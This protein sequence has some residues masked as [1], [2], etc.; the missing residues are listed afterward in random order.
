MMFDEMPQ[1]LNCVWA[2]S[3]AD[4]NCSWPGIP[5]FS[6]RAWTRVSSSRLRPRQF[7]QTVMDMLMTSRTNRR[8]KTA[9]K[10]CQGEERESNL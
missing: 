1:H 9:R 3:T 4:V 8:E 2:R 7:G 6:V 5:Y 10:Y